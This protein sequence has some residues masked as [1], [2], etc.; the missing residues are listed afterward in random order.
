MKK[1]KILITLGLVILLLGGIFAFKS[2]DKKEVDNTNKKKNDKSIEVVVLSL[3]NEKLTV[4]DKN[5]VI[6]TFDYN[7]ENLSI[8]NNIIIEYSGVL[9]KNKSIQ[10]SKVIGYTKATISKDENGIPLEYLDNGI[11]SQY[12][13]LANKKLEKMTLDEKISQLLLVRYPDIN[14]KAILEKY[15][16]GGYLFFAKDFKNKTKE[17]VINMMKELQEVSKVPI[18]TAVDEEGGTVVRVSSNPK[19]RS[20]RFKSSQVLYKEGGLELIKNDTIEKSNLLNSLGINLNLAPVVDVSTNP[21]D[22]MY[23]RSLG[24]N[25]E[26]TSN[27]AKTVIEAS[28]GLNV[29]YTLKHFPGYGNNSDTHTNS[30]VDNRSYEDIVNNDLPPFKSGIQV[31]AESILVSHNIVNSIDGDNP[32]SL[33]SS[34]HNLLRN[35]LSFTGIIITDDLAMGATSSI[36]NATLKAVL[37]GNDLIITT[38]YEDSFNQIKNSINDG[39]I[40]E[41]LIDKLAFRII[42]WKY[43]KGLLFTTK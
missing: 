13:V 1:R 21:D 19:L 25:T 33:S 37:A 14:Q 6:Y 42:A 38:D 16:F 23:N 29:S 28:K 40:S 12:Y 30:S 24:Q 2:F 43:Y 5:N 15:Q 34:I 36:E 27:Y 7:N 26:I 20:E 9:D 10:T 39:T 22:Y 31:G 18:L 41:E 35:E 32:A 4:Q 3:E 17:E 11:F 8:G